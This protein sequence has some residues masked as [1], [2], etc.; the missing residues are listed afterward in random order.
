MGITW[1]DAIAEFTGRSLSDT[2]MAANP[3]TG[4][5]ESASAVLRCPSSSNTPSNTSAQ[6][7][8]YSIN[9]G[10][11]NKG[12]KDSGGI[13]GMNSSSVAITF[14]ESS[15]N[16]PAQTIMLAE[17]PLNNN[18]VG[19]VGNSITIRSKL[20]TEV[21]PTHGNKYTY[22][23][24]DGHAELLNHEETYLDTNMWTARDDD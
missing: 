6:I 3:L 22:L 7:R 4:Y 17:R 2:D 13:S 8:T 19:A 5:D 21:K 15:V 10:E 14:S 1:D 24:C 18:L 20:D 9:A 16:N 12:G 11:N 23:F